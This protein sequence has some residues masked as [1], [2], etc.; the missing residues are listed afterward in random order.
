MFRC[1]VKRFSAGSVYLLVISTSLS[2]APTDNAWGNW[3][4]NQI[5]QHP[6][7]IAAR[8]QMNSDLSL[9]DGQD[10]PLYNPELETEF[11]REGESN[12]Y[13]IGINQTIDWWNKAGI[14]RQRATYS[15][16]ATRYTFELTR[17]QKTAQ[18]IGALI[19]W[20]S[21]KQQAQ[22]ASEQERQLET[23]LDVIKERQ[24]AGDLGQLDAE[25]TYLELSQKLSETAA[26]QVR[27]KR[28]ESRLRELLPD[29]SSGWG[30]IPRPFWKVFSANDHNKSFK[31]HPSIVASRA[32]WE[33]FRQQAKLVRQ[34]AKAEP[35][36]GLNAG[37]SGDDNV[38]SLSF[39]MPLNVRNTFSAETRSA[40]QRA[41]AAESQY[42]AVLR[43][44]QYAVEGARSALTEYQQHYLRWQTLMKG[45]VESSAKL[46]EKQWLSGDVSTP[47][48]LISLQ[49]RAEGVL[50][51]IEL[52]KQ[53]RMAYTD[54]L[55]QTGQITSALKQLK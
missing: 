4:Q 37:K 18:A 8:E 52:Q 35:S 51:G 24:Q 3:I 12:N 39:S 45:R 21:A 28:A 2:A 19:E 44:Q 11:E 50:A 40:N 36:F 32:E 17:Q 10:Q 7:V 46:L 54:W 16:Q 30:R 9:A 27:F 31:D 26:A 38:V 55:L 34:D 13:R 43:K 23:L 20:H 29:W 42:K 41:L 5:D 48:Y 49:Q 25:L 15:R 1:L 14:R 53:Y 6:E 47:E 22:L 33:S